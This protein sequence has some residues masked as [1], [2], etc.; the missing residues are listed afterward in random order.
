MYLYPG[1]ILFRAAREAFSL[2][3]YH[4]IVWEGSNSKFVEEE[5]VPDDCRV[6]GATWAKANKHGSRDRRFAD[7]YQIPTVEYGALVLRSNNGL[8]EEFQFSNLGKMVNW[9]NA[10]KAFGASF[11]AIGKSVPPS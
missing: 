1:F 5:K 4:D 10:L 2:I 6:L 3:E 8:W 7:N 9:L 11:A